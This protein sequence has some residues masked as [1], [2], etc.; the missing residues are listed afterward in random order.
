MRNLEEMRQSPRWVPS[1]WVFWCIRLPQAWQTSRKQPDEESYWA[2]CVT[3]W[4]RSIN[5]QWCC[6]A[7]FDVMVNKDRMPLLVRDYLPHSYLLSSTCSTQLLT[8]TLQWGE[9][10]RRQ[11][12]SNNFL[13]KTWKDGF[14]IRHEWILSELKLQKSATG[15]CGCWRS[16]TFKGTP[17][18]NATSSPSSVN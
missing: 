13:F 4:R 9:M 18:Q 12:P 17:V 1:S 15:L 7:R 16:L 8:G 6:A 14:W 3:S 10:D 2:S 5:N 11:S